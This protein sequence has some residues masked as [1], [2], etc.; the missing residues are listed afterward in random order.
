M[1]NKRRNKEVVG[2]VKGNSTMDTQNKPS[3]ADVQRYLRILNT[4]DHCEAQDP[5]KMGW[6]HMNESRGWK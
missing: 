2:Q 5:L 1:T 6:D 3:E 4:P